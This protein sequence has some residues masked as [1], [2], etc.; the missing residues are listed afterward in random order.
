MKRIRF[1]IASLL[2]MILILGVG[3]AALRESSDVWQRGFF[4]LT[5]GVLLISILLAIHQTEKKRAYWMGFAIFGWIYLC[6][7]LCRPLNPGS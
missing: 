4:T 7:L 2:V 1:N 3:F 5:L 6:S